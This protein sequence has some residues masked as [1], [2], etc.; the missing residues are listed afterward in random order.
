VLASSATD[1]TRLSPP[2]TEEVLLGLGANLGRPLE[3]LRAAVES[4]AR[5]VTNL[6][7]S[8]LYRTEPVGYA[9]QPEYLNV[10]CGGSTTLAPGELLAA[11]REIEDSLGRVRTAPNAP[12][13]IDIDI[14]A[15][16]SRVV[17]TP[18]LTIPHPRLAQRAF[19][20]V[21]LAEVA[22]QWRHPV[23]GLTAEEMLRAAGSLEKIE[24]IGELEECRDLLG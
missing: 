9:G 7:L 14:L 19:V 2:G 6:R 11:T 22:P 17:A 10:V 21:P 4:L 24:R 16:N 1:P 13:T 8:S 23:T 15:Y 5:I 12:R 20:L 18:E 3:Q